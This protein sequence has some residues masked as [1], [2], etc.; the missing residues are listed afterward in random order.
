M[1]FRCSYGA[2]SLLVS[3]VVAFAT[4]ANEASAHRKGPPRWG[5][6]SVAAPLSADS[7]DFFRAVTVGD[8]GAIYA[9]GYLVHEGERKTVVAKYTPDAALDLT[10]GPDGDG[11]VKLDLGPG[12]AVEEAWD[13]AVQSTGDLV[14]VGRA[15]NLG[16]TV[17]PTDVFLLRLAPSGELLGAPSVISL[18]PD[19][20]TAEAP[21]SRRQKR[22][23]SIPT[24]GRRLSALASEFTRCSW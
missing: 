3:T 22:R 16:G 24:G 21:A 15:E 8:G 19:P 18:G 13:V 17:S 6:A 23:R 12:A 7:D 14:V 11:T 10:F 9:A 4:T 5:A 2:L 20:A 1:H